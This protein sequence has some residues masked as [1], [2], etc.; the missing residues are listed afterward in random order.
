[1]IFFFSH[2]NDIIDMRKMR[3]FHKKT[4]NLKEKTNY[5]ENENMKL[6]GE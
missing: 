1:M 2:N 5:G 6:F 4:Q 3:E